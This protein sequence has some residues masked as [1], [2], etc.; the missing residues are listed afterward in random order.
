MDINT[1]NDKQREALLATE[2][3]L[4]ILAGA[5]SGKTK[6]VTSKIAYLIEEL[7]VPSW[8]ILAITFTNK[9]AKEMKD[10]VANLIDRD[11][12]SMWIGTFHSICVRILRKNIESIGYSS[13]FTIYDRDDQITV[14]KEAIAELNLDRD[15]YKPR[16]I[17]NDISDTSVI[18]DRNSLV[19]ALDRAQV[20]SDPGKANLIRIE[21]AENHMVIKSN[22]EVGDVKEVI[23]TEQSGED[24][25]IAFNARYMQEGVKA[26]ESDKIKLTFKSSLNPCL[27]Y[28]VDS[29]YE[30]E[31]F[32]YLV[33]P[34]RL[35]N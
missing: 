18:L 19:R 26:N 22:S 11:I 20:L 34:V 30:D 10:R 6:V 2:G 3:P 14:V 8:K 25:D 17:I 24:L 21:V 28:P 32:T 7:K 33:L 9:A 1:L 12:S 31:E 29:K 4:L 16:A 27:I 13:N 35:A 15:I 23:E 5:G